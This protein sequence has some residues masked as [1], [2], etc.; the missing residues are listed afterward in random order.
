MVESS[1]QNL[2]KF[3]SYPKAELVLFDCDGVLVDSEPAAQ[4]ASVDFAAK[5]G[6][7]MTIPEA[8]KYFLG[9]SMP[10]IIRILRKL[11]S[12][13]LPENAD[14][15]LKAHFISVMKTEAR[16]FDGVKSLLQ[17]LNKAGIPFHVG[18]NSSMD[19]MQAKFKAVKIEDEIDPNKVHSAVDMGKPKPA[20]DV[21][22]LGAEEEKISPEKTIV[23]EDSDAG[24]KAAFN[25]GMRCIL[26]RHPGQ[27]VP[28][29]FKE[30]QVA[31]AYN[32]SDV[33]KILSQAL[34]EK[35]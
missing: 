33:E 22:L 24:A 11:S 4:K 17:K 1:S 3:L 19:E 2:E 32:I 18:S 16:T 26:L 34:R 13:E 15:L 25:A 8:E 35:I 7:Q 23:V 31:V 21:Y 30:G 5:Y 29:F 6:I 14:E 12:E 27:K 9:H 10:E 20:P 28:D